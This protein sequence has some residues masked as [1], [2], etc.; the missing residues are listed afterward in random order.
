MMKGGL[1]PGLY[2]ISVYTDK[3]GFTHNVV[4]P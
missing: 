1:E 3:R 2:L 4:V